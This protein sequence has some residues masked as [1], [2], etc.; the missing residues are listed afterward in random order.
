M[1]HHMVWLTENY[2]PQRGGMA[3]SCDR[4]VGALRQAGY[5][6][7]VVHFTHQGAAW[8]PIQ[9]LNGYYMAI[10]F[11]DSEAHTLNRTWEVLRHRPMSVLVCFGGYLP[12]LAAPVYA[13]WAGIPLVVM[14]R[15]NDFDAAVFT[16]RKRDLLR[17]ALQA[18]QAICT[19]ASGKIAKIQRFFGVHPV[20]Y[21]PNSLDVD[22]WVPSPS[23]TRFAATWRSEQLPAGRLCIG[24]F[25]QLKAK[26]GIDVLL[27]AL[28]DSVL[29][30]QVHLLL[31]GEL[32]EEQLAGL[33][34]Q[35]V[36]FSHLPFLDRYALLK[37]Y[38]CCDALIIPSYY[39]GMPNVLLEGGALGVPVMA[40]AVDGMEDVIRHGHNG[41]LFNAGQPLACRKALFDFIA[42]PDAARQELGSNLRTTIREHYT[43]HHETHLYDTLFQTLVDM[44]VH[45]V[46]LHQQQQPFG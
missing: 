16:P 42:M 14:L 3:Q 40:S 25:G 29:Q 11:D 7:D 8:Q 15:G 27:E 36:S 10:P 32:T 21:I 24:M 38:L 2:P 6:I 41:L 43:L 18:A 33:H 26:K 28:A 20:R 4:I 34:L 5:T 39:D 22:S 1:K 19:V 17:D 23:E 35:Q 12:V 31:I 44:P 45:P 13:R 30:D 37:Y 9:Q 46:Q